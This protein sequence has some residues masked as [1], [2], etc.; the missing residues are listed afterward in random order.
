MKSTFLRILLVGLLLWI[1]L[2]A[3]APNPS[4]PTVNFT[5]LTPLPA[6]LQVGESYTVVVQVDSAADYLFA[7]A[8]P[9]PEYPGRYVVFSGPDRAGGGTSSVL[10]L[11][12]TGKNST[13]VDFPEGVPVQFVVMTRFKGGVTASQWYRFNVVVP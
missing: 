6:T 2:V 9:A 4:P 7:M 12:L 13:A 10:S 5:L 11:T 3:A 1:V 8:I